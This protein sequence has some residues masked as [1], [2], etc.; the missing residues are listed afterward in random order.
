VK[1]AGFTLLEVMVALV[2]IGL[3]LTAAVRASES[4]VNGAR[5]LKQQLAADWVA[6]NRLIDLQAHDGWP[7]EGE[8]D[9]SEKQG[10]DTYF[11]KQVVS[12]TP[13]PLFRKLDVEVYDRQQAKGYLVRRE[14]FLIHIPAAAA[15]D[16]NSTDTAVSVA[17]ETGG[18][19]DNSVTVTTDPGSPQ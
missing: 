7:A 4:A 17:P 6:Q 1:T 13:N 18:Q 14:G 19:A 15:A 8:T 9:G 12:S 3:A 5:A 10:N 11:W 16:P 2:I